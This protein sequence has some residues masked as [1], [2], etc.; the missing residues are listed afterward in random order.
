MRSRSA[1]ANALVVGVILLAIGG[2]AGVEV[3]WEDDGGVK[4]PSVDVSRGGESLAAAQ[5]LRPV[6]GVC[7]FSW[8]RARPEQLSRIND[9]VWMLV[10]DLQK[11][12]TA[13]H[14]Y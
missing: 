11:D 8:R 10:D 13:V 2:G 3:I 9:R 1:G 4:A 5:G 7:G 14:L 12:P 6:S